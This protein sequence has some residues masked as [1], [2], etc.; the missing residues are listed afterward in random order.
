MESMKTQITIK[1]PQCSSSNTSPCK[2]YQ[3]VHNGSHQLLDHGSS[4]C[5]CFGHCRKAP[6]IQRYSHYA[7][8]CLTSVCIKEIA[9]Y[10]FWVIIEAQCQKEHYSEKKK[11]H[12]V[13]NNILANS[14]CEVIFLTLTVEGKKHDKKIVDE[15]KYR[16]PKGSILFQ[17]TGFQ[18]F[19]AEDVLILQP[20]KS[21]EVKI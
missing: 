20:A 18:G 17:D 2:T 19:P 10:W 21:Q 8:S 14:N 3:T 6:Y 7:E 15:S 13:K 4:S 16:L 11:A 12:T 1:C 5:G 9:V